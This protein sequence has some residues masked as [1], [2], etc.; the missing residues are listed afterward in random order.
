MHNTERRAL[1]DGL[2]AVAFFAAAFPLTDIARTGFA[3][4]PLLFGTVLGAGAFALALLALFGAF[5]LWYRALSTGIARASQLQ[6]LLPLLAALFA[7]V[8]PEASL[9]PVLWLHGAAVIAAVAF[10]WKQVGQTFATPKE[11]HP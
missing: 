11:I 6:C 8:L 3:P 10:T 7:A 5:C 9:P 2:T 4:L 1:R